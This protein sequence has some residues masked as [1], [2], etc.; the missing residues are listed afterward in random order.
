[1][2]HLKKFE[3]TLQSAED[4]GQV[5]EV[6]TKSEVLG[7]I[8]DI[9]NKSGELGGLEVTE[10][11]SKKGSSSIKYLQILDRDERSIG[12]YISE[13]DPTISNS[14]EPYKGI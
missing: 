12:I 6:P 14:Q 3:A 2:K 5:P 7:K 10:V 11:V 1:M 9:L 8:K 4:S 13:I